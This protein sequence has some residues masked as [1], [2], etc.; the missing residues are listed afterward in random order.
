MAYTQKNHPYPVTS[1]GRRRSFMTTGNPVPFQKT[2]PLNKA[3][4]KVCLPYNKVMS[5]SKQERQKVINAKQ[6]AANKGEKRRS[7]KSW[8]RDGSTKS[9]GLRHWVKQNWVQ[10]GNPSKKC[11]EK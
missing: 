3:T 10:V 4:R 6:S 1:C 11:G 7:S 5:M 2:S 9:K 8:I